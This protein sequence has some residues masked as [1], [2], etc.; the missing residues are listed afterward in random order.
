M[1]LMVNQSGG[2]FLPVLLKGYLLGTVLSAIVLHVAIAIIAPGDGGTFLVLGD[3]VIMFVI[4]L[5]VGLIGL[6]SF[7]VAAFASWPFR[8]LVF[9]RP[10]LALVIAV[11]VG[12]GTG[13][14]LTAIE[15]QVGPGDF[16]SGPLV[17]LIY[18]GVWFWVVRS[19]LHSKIAQEA[20]TRG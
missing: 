18:S 14:V 1:A 3:V 2:R 5:F 8:Q 15:F 11:G 9:E 10:L 12:V 19:S 16:W 13:A 4:L 17:G 20:Q 6:V 7:P